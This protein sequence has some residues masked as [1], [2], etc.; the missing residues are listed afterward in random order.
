MKKTS[1]FSLLFFLSI[2]LFVNCSKS[3]LKGD[4]TITMITVNGSEMMVCSQEAIIEKQ[5]I[6]LSELVE[7]CE[8]V[9]FELSEEAMFKPWWT[10]VTDN[11]ISIRQENSNFK[12]FNRNGKFLCDVGSMGQGPG[13]YPMSI[14]NEVIDEKNGR[15]YFITFI[16]DKILTYDMKGNH[17]K[18]IPLPQKFNKPVIFLSR[19]D[20]ITIIHLPFPNN[21]NFALQIDLDGNVLKELP[22]QNHF[23]CT[24]YDHEIFSYK[25]TDAFDFFYTSVDTLFHFD[26][27]KNELKPVYTM[28]FPPSL[29]SSPWIHQY[30]E[31]PDQYITYIRNWETNK[32]SILSTNKNN[33]TSSY[34]KIINDFYGGM[35]VSVFSF[36]NG[37]FAHNVEPGELID[38][39]E[40][41]LTEKSCTKDD[42]EKLNALLATLDENSNNLLFVGKLKQ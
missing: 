32:S 15:I 19:D 10:I 9:R 27:E 2:G 39:I 13:E 7:S 14:K 25:N 23:L 6:S 18:D 24:T 41:R 11:Y 36:K 33:Q 21:N 5:V 20:K 26:V 30:L 8:L 3:S 40:K 17:L 37:Y 35:E 42:K 1:L 16:G 28:T 38:M 34:I 31:L 22:K 12:L 29:S 4:G